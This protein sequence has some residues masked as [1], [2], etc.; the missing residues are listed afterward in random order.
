VFAFAGCPAAIAIPGLVPPAGGRS[1]ISKSVS[2]SANNSS[3]EASAD[4]SADAA[5]INIC[6]DGDDMIHHVAYLGA[7]ATAA[8][9]LAGLVGLP[10]SYLAGGLQL[11]AKQAAAGSAARHANAA[12]AAAAAAALGGLQLGSGQEGPQQP[13]VSMRGIAG[14]TPAAEPG[15]F[16][17]Q[18]DVL[19]QLSQPWAQLLFHDGLV[20][21]RQQL[22]QGQSSSPTEA[23]EEGQGTV[24]GG[25]KGSLQEQ[26]QD[27]VVQLL[28]R[29]GAE[30]PGYKK[31]ARPVVP[32][33][34]L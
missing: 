5:V 15:V 17:L 21:L 20:Q 7:G 34:V 1:L 33:V 28:Q 3:G 14:V 25:G 18:Q 19:Q 4:A 8:G 16:L 6:I 11:P 22:L 13:C 9:K 23:R 2:S 26:V 24:V 12:G 29:C 27:A 32:P 10:F 30:L 31:E